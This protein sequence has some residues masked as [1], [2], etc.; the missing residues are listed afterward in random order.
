LLAELNDGDAQ[1]LVAAMAVPKHDRERLSSQQISNILMEEGWDVPAKSVENHRKG[2]C[3][4]GSR[5]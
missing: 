3:R 2:G 5:N 4:C 1:A